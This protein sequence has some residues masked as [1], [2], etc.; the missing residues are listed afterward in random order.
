MEK[1]RSSN[2]P[3][4]YAVVLHVCA[5]P[6]LSA[7][8]VGGDSSIIRSQV[9]KFAAFNELNQR[10]LGDKRVRLARLENRLRCHQSGGNRNTGGHGP[11]QGLGRSKA[12]GITAPKQLVSEWMRMKKRNRE[13]EPLQQS[14]EEGIGPVDGT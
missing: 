4:D 5:G 13:S 2:E 6:E 8:E 3:N 12:T 1:L 7:V 14:E 9:I 10:L 11:D